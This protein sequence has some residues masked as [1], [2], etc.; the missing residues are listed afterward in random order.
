MPD[1]GLVGVTV[2]NRARESAVEICIVDRGVGIPADVAPK[3]FDP[4]FTTKR[5][6]ADC[7]GPSLS[8]KPSAST[9]G[10]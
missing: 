7:R 2:A 8:V 9:T 6:R 10:T 5:S 3:V 1:G 4:F